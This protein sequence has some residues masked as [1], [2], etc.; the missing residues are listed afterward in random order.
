MAPAARV[1]EGAVRLSTLCTIYSTQPQ[2]GF[3]LVL[4]HYATYTLEAPTLLV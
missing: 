4:P 3:T 2:Q 1:A